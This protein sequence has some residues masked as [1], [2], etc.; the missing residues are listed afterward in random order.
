MKLSSQSKHNINTLFVAALIIGIQLFWGTLF[1]AQMTWEEYDRQWIKRNPETR[2]TILN[3]AFGH[4]Q[5]ALSAL[6][7]GDL[8]IAETWARDALKVEPEF[9]EGYFLL[10]DIYDQK[11]KTK[12]ATKY[13]IKGEKFTDRPPII[14]ERAYLEQN[15]ERLKANYQPSQML[16]RIVLYLFL[17]VAYGVIIF[18]IISS[19]LF[20]SFSMGARHA[21]RSM[22]EKKEKG[23][24]VVIGTFHDERQDPLFSWPFKLVIYTL[25]FLVCFLI[26]VLCGAVTKKEV[27]LFTFFPGLLIDVLIYKIIFSDDDF[28]PPQRF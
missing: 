11:G 8:T 26:T 27:F 16:N 3:R 5:K 24:S 22:K 12:R 4:Y 9:A 15:L 10:A 19:G 23:G 20:T 17:L 18:L 2:L 7:N 14:Q 21:I 1:G 13:R 6:R 28:Q 25:P